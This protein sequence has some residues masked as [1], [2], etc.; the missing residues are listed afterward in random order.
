MHSISPKL[1]CLIVDDEPM[2]QEVLATHIAAIPELE[3]V[4]LCNNVMEAFEALHKS[5]IDLIFLDINMPVISGLS[6]LRSLKDPP[7]IILTTAYP[8]YALDGYE[9]DVVDYLLKPIPPARLQ[10]SVKKA[11]ARLSGQGR[12]VPV[13]QQQ[14]AAPAAA[15]TQTVPEKNYFFVKSDGKLVK[16]NYADIRYIEG[17]KDYLKIY[18]AAGQPVVIHQTMKGM[19]EQ[20]PAAK[21]MRVHKSY[22]I[23][24]DAIRAIDGAIVHV[25][26]NEIP[27]GST[28]REALLAKI[29]A[30]IQ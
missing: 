16:I 14:D 2:A 17:M 20:L 26:K 23:A 28:Y 22:I 18:L 8:E 11:I 6:F 19:E 7:A 1:R 4:Q 15:T 24:L 10:A 5:H 12:E 13:I 27:L 29:S 25:D 3:I 30:G 21:F 9:L